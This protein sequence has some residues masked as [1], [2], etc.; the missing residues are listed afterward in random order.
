MRVAASKAKNLLGGVRNVNRQR[1]RT[2][3]RSFL[4]VIHSIRH[5]RRTIVRVWTALGN[6]A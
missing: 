5:Q 4:S 6:A 2:E 1:K 3:R